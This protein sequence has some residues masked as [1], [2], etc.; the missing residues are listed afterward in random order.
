M[1]A[2]VLRVAR[3]GRLPYIF[4][5]SLVINARAK[6][7]EYVEKRVKMARLEANWYGKLVQ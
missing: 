6:G 3:Y 5:S 7:N 1:V 2:L 4:Y